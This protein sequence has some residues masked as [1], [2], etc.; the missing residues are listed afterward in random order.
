M[1][2]DLCMSRAFNPNGWKL[3]EISLTVQA[4]TSYRITPV[5]RYPR[6]PLLL[7]D[8]YK[9]TP[10]FHPDKDFLEVAIAPIKFVPNRLGIHRR[11]LASFKVFF[12]LQ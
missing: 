11:V 10:D 9:A 12:G 3:N 7:K 8:L 1:I 4:E 5:L 2:K 6:Y